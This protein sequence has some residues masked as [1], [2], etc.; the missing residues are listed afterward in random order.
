MVSRLEFAALSAHRRATDALVERADGELDEDGDGPGTATAVADHR[1]NA[2]SEVALLERCFR[3]TLDDVVDLERL[4]VSRATLFDH[5]RVGEE[6][7]RVASFAAD[8][9]RATEGEP[10]ADG[11]AEAFADCARRTR[12]SIEAAT[13]AAL[14]GTDLEEAFDARDEARRCAEAARALGSDEAPASG[15]PSGSG[16]WFLAAGALERTARCGATIGTR[17]LR[18][19]LRRES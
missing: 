15:S 16:S 7:E 8:I 13:D 3:R 6:L 5:L 1:R 11:P 14:S 9:A 12:L 18:T 2:A 19:A 10:P 17:S 4:G